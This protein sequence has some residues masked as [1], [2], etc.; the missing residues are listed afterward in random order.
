MTRLRSALL[1]LCAYSL[2]TAAL[3]WAGLRVWIGGVR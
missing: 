2:L 3:V 1:L